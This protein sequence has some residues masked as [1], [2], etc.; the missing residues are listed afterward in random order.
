MEG[1]ANETIAQRLNILHTDI[2]AKEF[3]SQFILFLLICLHL[4]LIDHIMKQTFVNRFSLHNIIHFFA[5]RF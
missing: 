1:R 3:F 2:P 4:S 5:T